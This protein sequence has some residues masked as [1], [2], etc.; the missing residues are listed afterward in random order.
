MSRADPAEQALIRLELRRFAS[1][2]DLQES[3]IQRA[4][5]LREVSRLVSLS[6]PY[7][8]AS[9]FE[10]RDLQRRVFHVAEERARQLIVEQVDVYMRGEPGFREKMH[11]KLR[12]DWMNLTGQLAHL[13]TWA[14]ARLNVAEQNR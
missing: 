2:C 10:A 12:E 13:R 8:L 6:V 3:S 9:E 11:G 1:R 4:D 5:T 14:H 7:K